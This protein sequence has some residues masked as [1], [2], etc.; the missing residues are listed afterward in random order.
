MTKISLNLSQDV[1]LVNSVALDIIVLGTRCKDMVAIFAEG[2]E[3]GESAGGKPGH[4]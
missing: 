2:K 4:G 3:Y 1:S